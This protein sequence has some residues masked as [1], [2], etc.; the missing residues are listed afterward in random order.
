MCSTVFLSFL[1]SF[2]IYISSTI[3][4]SGEAIRRTTTNHVKSTR[5]WS[6]RL[7]DRVLSN[8]ASLLQPPDPPHHPARSDLNSSRRV[9]ESWRTAGLVGIPG[10]HRTALVPT[11][12]RTRGRT[13]RRRTMGVP[14]L[15]LR[16]DF[17]SRQ[18]GRP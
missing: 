18:E 17:R 16:T 5:R 6:H 12:R 9:G 8:A 13:R 2:Y 10:M 3:T 11:T 1:L 15:G 4:N 14:A 7:H